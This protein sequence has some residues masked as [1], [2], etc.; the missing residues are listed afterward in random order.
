MIYQPGDYVYPLD[1]PRAYLCRVRRAESLGVRAGRS[2]MLRLQPLEGPWAPG[3]ELVRLDDG[4]LP[5]KPRQLWQ[6][7]GT[8]TPRAR[9]RDAA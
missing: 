7:R 3:T 6:Q 8:W 2:Q 1:L 5:A 9:H 4:V